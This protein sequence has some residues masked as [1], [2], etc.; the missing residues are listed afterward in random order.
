[1]RVALCLL[2]LALAGCEDSASDT[3]RV[4]L[5]QLVPTSRRV[6]LRADG[7]PDPT[8]L[9]GALAA[10]DGNTAIDADIT[11]LSRRA[12]AAARA[13]LVGAG[14]DPDRVRIA[15]PGPGAPE[16]VLTTMH[17][18]TAPCDQAPH[19]GAF[20]EAA[21]SLDS[22]GR[23]VQQNNLAEMLDDP[24]DL[25]RSPVPEPGSGERAARAV[26]LLDQGQQQPLPVVQQGLQAPFSGGL[27]G[28]TAAAA[29][30]PAASQGNPL[31]GPLP[32]AAAVPP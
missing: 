29:G 16:L 3:G 5:V 20:G 8:A 13:A 17:V 7:T 21:S 19:A 10:L 28:G 23:C 11:G 30:T 22:I 4:P 6:P 24:M 2:L 1:M 26:R 27:F 32:G 18:A 9:A 14:L 15:P 31:L 12:S 25:V